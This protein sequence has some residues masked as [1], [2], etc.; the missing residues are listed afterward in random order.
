MEAKG[1]G[2]CQVLGECKTK[3]KEK[4]LRRMGRI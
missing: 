1:Y 4:V 2:F 3:D